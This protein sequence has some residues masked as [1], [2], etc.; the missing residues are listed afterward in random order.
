MVYRHKD[1]TDHD[2]WYPPCFG[3]S[4]QKVDLMFSL[5]LG[6]LSKAL[7]P[8]LN[9]AEDSPHMAQDLPKKDSPKGFKRP[10]GQSGNQGSK[11]LFL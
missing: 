6:L 2:F 11:W 5:S 7:P 4:N 10:K 3:P 1:P 9:V 8:A